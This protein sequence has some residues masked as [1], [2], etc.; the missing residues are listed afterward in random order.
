MELQIGTEVILSNERGGI[1]AGVVDHFEKDA[2]VIMPT[3]PVMKAWYTRGYALDKAHWDSH[4]TLV[5][6][7]KMP[8]RGQ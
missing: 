6:A 8:G 4:L 3:D 1:L 5:H 2:A 7:P